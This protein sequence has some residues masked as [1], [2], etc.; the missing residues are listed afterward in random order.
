MYAEWVKLS[1]LPRF[2]PSR[3]RAATFTPWYIAHCLIFME[4]SLFPSD[5]LK[6]SCIPQNNREHDLTIPLII[7]LMLDG[8]NI[9][10]EMIFYVLV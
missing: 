9:Y 7:Q 3:T 4:Y 6:R 10:L 5:Y 1:H 2:Y 8:N